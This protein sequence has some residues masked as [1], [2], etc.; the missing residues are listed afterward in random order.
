R[1]RLIFTSAPADRSLSSSRN[2]APATSV[3]KRWGHALARTTLRRLIQAGRGKGT[4]SWGRSRRRCRVSGEQ[5]IDLGMN[6]LHRKLFLYELV[7]D[8]E[9]R[10]PYD[11][12]L[13]SPL[14]DPFQALDHALILPARIEF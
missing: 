12:E 9:I 13:A 6:V 11:P 7:L 10:R 3:P 14:L 4:L 5:R 2:Q 8:E 1:R